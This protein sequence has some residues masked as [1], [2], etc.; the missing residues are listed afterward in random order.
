G[1]IYERARLMQAEPSGG[2]MAA[3][4]APAETVSGALQT[5]AGR[6]DIAAVN[7]PR[8]TVI[9]GAGDEVK[10]LLAQFTAAGIKSKELVVSHAFHS[11]LTEP[12]LDPFE[13]AAGKVV[14]NAPRLRL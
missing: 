2:S 4:L 6:V 3:V 13:R 5:M 12:M 11:P 8:Q 1:L 14:F 10:A 7:G 9:S